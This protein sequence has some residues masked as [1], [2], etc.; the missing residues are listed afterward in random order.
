VNDVDYWLSTPE[1]KPA[2]Q[3]PSE[4]LKNEVKP[5][6]PEPPVSVAVET[7]KSSKSKK[8]KS[9]KKSKEKK[10]KHKKKPRDEPEVQEIQPDVPAE[11]PSM[12]SLVEV[13]QE[14][15]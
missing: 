8:S 2:T 10:H 13:E 7:P 15:E 6:L 4:S 9:E 14:E 11:E 1:P 5:D 3:T 12:I